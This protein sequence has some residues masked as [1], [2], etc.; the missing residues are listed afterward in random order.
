MIVAKAWLLVCSSSVRKGET[1]VPGPLVLAGGC[2]STPRA[3]VLCRMEPI[4]MKVASVVTFEER[5]KGFSLPQEV[6]K[7]SWGTTWWGHRRA[8]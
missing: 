1:H 2:L 4:R 8:H 5:L 3:A 6:L 7:Q